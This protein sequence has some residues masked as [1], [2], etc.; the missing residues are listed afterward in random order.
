MC[1]V[2]IAFLPALSGEL[3]T[4]NEQEYFGM[5]KVGVDFTDMIPA[6]ARV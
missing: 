2:G 5:H 6:S 3:T 4:A 1:P